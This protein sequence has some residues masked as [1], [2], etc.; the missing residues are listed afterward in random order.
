MNRIAYI[1]FKTTIVVLALLLGFC[2]C[3]DNPVDDKPK[4]TTR[5]T[6]V[7]TSPDNGDSTVSMNSAIRVTFSEAMATASMVA[8]TLVLDPPV[9][10]T[11]SYSN[12]VLTLTPSSALDTNVTYLATVTT[13]AKDTAGNSLASAHTW[14]FT[15]Y[16]D[17]IPPTV[18]TTEPREGDSTTVNS[19]IQVIFS[20]SMD[21]T[22][23]NA[24][25]IQFDPAISGTYTC[26]A[27][28]L[29]TITPD[30]PLDLP[31][32]YTATVTTGV[33]DSSGNYL[34]APYVWHFHTIAD[35]VPPT[36]LLVKP[37][38][39]TVISD[40]LKIQ[41][42]ASDNDRLD[43]VEFYAD[44]VHLTGTDDTTYPYEG[45]WK[46]SGLTLGSEHTIYAI[47]YDESGNSTVSDTVTVHYLWRLLVTD[48]NEVNPVVIPRNLSRIYTRSSTSQ[49][50]FRVET[51]NGW[52]NYKSATEG[53]DVAIFLDVD[54]DST[55]G[56]IT[57][58]SG[59]IR[60]GDIGADYRLVVGL[61]GDS[62]GRWTGSAWTGSGQ[63]EN[64]V[65]STNSNYFEASV[66][67]LL[68]GSP[69]AVDVIVANAT[70]NTVAE[71]LH[72]DW[73]PNLVDGHVTI[74]ID[75]TYSGSTTATTTA[76]LSQSTPNTSAT[77]FD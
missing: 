19:V 71:E 25:T 34:A 45:V 13:A 72:W 38:D 46:P 65:I 29:V 69:G 74:D 31:G 51:Y 58:N 59:A 14:E 49:L 41:V 22:S 56:A 7:A 15:T 26:S 48:N 42:E 21:T 37:E 50:Q 62:V 32:S 4:D 12:K 1:Y 70:R 53:I 35:G 44:G 66:S 54:Q 9:S 40:S 10:G 20:E 11:V 76:S 73:A 30:L 67:L 63:V 16:L 28:R 18:A 52:S 33:R 24:S 77:P 68:L 6:V 64:L 75:H 27:N 8:G 60:I 36:V 3:G 2:S 47:A 57:A 5:P 17:T 61:H 55:T 39:N 43:R 23:L